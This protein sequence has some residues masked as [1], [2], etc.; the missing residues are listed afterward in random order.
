MAVTTPTWLTQH[1][2]TLRVGEEGKSASVYFAG[3]LQY[4]LV[5]VPAKGKYSCRV[6][7][8]INGKRLDGSNTY[9][10]AEDAIRGGLEDLRQAL[11]W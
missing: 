11:G 3:A 1:D 10:S 4:L 8:T 2:G 7:Q 5:P 6:I 9:A